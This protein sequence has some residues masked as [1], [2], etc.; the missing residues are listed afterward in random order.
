MLLFPSH[1]AHIV[2]PACFLFL[3]HCCFLK[4]F[5][6]IFKY[7]PVFSAHLFQFWVIY[8]LIAVLSYCVLRVREQKGLQSKYVTN[9]VKPLIILLIPWGPTTARGSFKCG[10]KTKGGF[11]FHILLFWSFLSTAIM[12]NVIK[13]RLQSLL[14]FI[15]PWQTVETRI[16]KW[17]QTQQ[18]NKAVT[19]KYVKASLFYEML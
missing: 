12:N 4:L 1:V 15:K 11:F 5:S 3:T 14:Q 6:V 17:S 9:I 13:T 16:K 10:L 7:R 18:E 19:T 8:S 2:F